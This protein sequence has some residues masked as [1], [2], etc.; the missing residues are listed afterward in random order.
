MKRPRSSFFELTMLTR[1]LKESFKMLTPAIQIRNPVM[2]VTYICSLLTT[3][4]VAGEIATWSLSWF[5][6]QITL[7][8]WFTVLFSNFS[9]SIAESRGK[10]QA[11]SLR[12]TKVDAYARQIRNGIEI[13]TPSVDLKKDDVIICIADDIIP[14]DGEVMEGVAMVD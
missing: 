9:E 12:K 4:Y 3:L 7:W 1:S 5:D 2:F 14:A 8:L 6:L 13:K 11:E 10:A